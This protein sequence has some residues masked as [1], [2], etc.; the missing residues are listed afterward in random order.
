MKT[1][2]RMTAT[3]VW[4]ILSWILILLL[5]AATPAL[6]AGLGFHRGVHGGDHRARRLPGPHPPRGPAAPHARGPAGR[7]PDRAE[8]HHHELVPG[9]VRGDGVQ[10]A[11]PPVRLVVGAGLAVA[12]RR[13]AGGD[14][15]RDRHAGGHSKQL[16]RS[17]SHGGSRPDTGLQRAVSIRASPDV[18][19]KRVI[20]MIGIPLALGSY[21]GLL[22]VVP[23]TA[24]LAL[25]IFDEE[26]LLLQELPG[27]PDYTQKVRYRLAPYLW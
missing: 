11:R 1:G 2:L 12:A 14:R 18:H 19:R 20:M 23:G 24:L 8:V 22:F 21:W 17:D 13:R 10:R 15:P 7:T 4:G 25:R 6:L 3:S 16:R 9:P 26:K 5:P 27:Y